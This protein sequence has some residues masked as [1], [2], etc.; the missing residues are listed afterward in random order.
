[1]SNF[2]LC[3]SAA[4]QAGLSK[5]AFKV[6][7]FLAISANSK[8]RSS[9]KAKETIA[10]SCK[11]S[12]STVVRACRELCKKGMLEIRKRFWGNGKQTSNLYILLDNPQLRTSSTRPP[13]DKRS[14]ALTDCTEMA[15]APHGKSQTKPRLFKCESSAFHANLSPNELKIY[16]YI[17][18]RAG[19]DGQCLPSKKNIAADCGISVS[20]VFRAVKK[21]CQTG[22]LEVQSQTRM[23]TCG[24][25]GTSV[26][27]YVLKDNTTDLPNEP[28]N[29]SKKSAG[30]VNIKTS[31]IP[32]FL[33]FLTPSLMSLVTPQRTMS[34]NKVT[35]KQRK[36]Y[37]ISKLTK[38]NTVH[39][40]SKPAGCRKC[41]AKSI[42]T[43][44]TG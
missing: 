22:L 15:K 13:K 12:V 42:P 7:S 40:L 34:R 37:L 16:S 36:G 23:E 31:M 35:L 4:L 10:K 19:K 24:N 32:F 18:F 26:N 33:P 28:L 41:P 6:Y 5:S 29:I 1:M 25:N 38:R 9:F 21:L 27:L 14:S 30:N 44:D 8:T 11:V 2:Y 3:N 20:T 43:L 17:S 39:I